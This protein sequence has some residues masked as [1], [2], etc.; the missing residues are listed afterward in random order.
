MKFLLFL[1]GT[2]F[3]TLAFFGF[4]A[5]NDEKDEN[6]IPAEIVRS[7]SFKKRAA[8]S[9]ESAAKKLPKC[10]LRKVFLLHE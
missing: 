7:D 8:S 9:A 3:K 10:A 1:L 4:V 2:F 5:Y 6:L